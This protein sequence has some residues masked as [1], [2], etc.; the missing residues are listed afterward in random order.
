MVTCLKISRAASSTFCS[1]FSVFSHVVRKQCHLPLVYERQTKQKQNYRGVTA[2]HFWV[3]ADDET[4][5]SVYIYIPCVCKNSSVFQI[6]ASSL[7]VILTDHYFETKIVLHSLSFGGN[8]FLQINHSLCHLFVVCKDEKGAVF[9]LPKL[10]SNNILWHLEDTVLKAESLSLL[11]VTVPKR[12]GKGW[13]CCQWK[14]Q[15]HSLMVVNY[16]IFL[17]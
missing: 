5:T 7:L 15:K 10:Q 17:A 12:A 3:A 1:M 8:M 14:S 2:Q 9:D 16:Y 13:H 6:N 4:G 11:H